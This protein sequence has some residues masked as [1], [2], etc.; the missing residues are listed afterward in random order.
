MIFLVPSGTGRG[1]RMTGGVEAMEERRSGVR[2]RIFTVLCVL[3]AANLLYGPA[4]FMVLY[5]APDP[6]VFG[7]TA[8][9]VPDFAAFWA[10]ARLTL[11]GMPALAYDWEAHRAVEVAGFGRDFPGL[12]PWHYPPPFQLIVAPLGA[13]PLWPAMAIWVALSGFMFLAVCWRILPRVEAL[14]AALAAAPT[15]MTIVNGQ[16]AFLIAAL[17][18]AGL[19][20]TERRRPFAGAALGALIVKPQF[21]LAAPLALAAGRCWR[22]FWIA[23]VTVVILCSASWLVLGT[24]TWAAFL[25]SIGETTAVFA[26][27]HI[28]RWAM[29]ANL[30]GFLRWLGLPFGPSFSFQLVL[31][32]A[33]LALL[34]RVWGRSDV[35]FA[36][37]AALFC[38]ASVAASPRVLNYDLHL[39]AI[40]GLFEARHAL[41]AGPWRGEILLLAAALVG[42]F[43]SMVFAPGVAP[44]LAPALIMGLWWGHLRR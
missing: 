13:L 11:E 41:A 12:M 30:Y 27:D 17:A 5:V 15:A 24:A 26:S 42:A 21:A 1:V 40:G 14:L 44:F 19:L 6:A 22:T 3:A 9:P 28:Q 39:L 23:A 4:L 36:L 7:V 20:G 2:G 25:R 18:G 33:V 8:P 43:A 10:A 16:A 32:S 38:Y 34:W 37:K 31:S 35:C 29:G